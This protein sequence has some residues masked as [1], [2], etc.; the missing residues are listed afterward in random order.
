M[1]ELLFTK[2]KPIFIE[3]SEVLGISTYLASF[4]FSIM[5]FVFDGQSLSLIITS[6]AGAV[7]ILIGGYVKYLN[8]KMRKE[9]HD[10]EMRE[11]NHK[12]KLMVEE[13]SEKGE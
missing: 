2:L 1:K 12:Y 8:A 3:I 5:K 9:K 13:E 6:S 7:V 4:G 10:A 11:I